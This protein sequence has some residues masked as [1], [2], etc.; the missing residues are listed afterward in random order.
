[1]T[2]MGRPLAD[3]WQT[4]G[5]HT[6]DHG[7]LQ[8]EPSCKISQMMICLEAPACNLPTKADS[9]CSV[10]T[11]RKQRM[12]V[13]DTPEGSWTRSQHSKPWHIFIAHHKRT[14]IDTTYTY[15]FNH[16]LTSFL[17]PAHP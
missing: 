6:S 15:T 1:M 9:V 12:W 14:Y 11:F 17:G 3:L 5:R 2:V 16:H 4:F 10:A 7:C 13:N 8:C